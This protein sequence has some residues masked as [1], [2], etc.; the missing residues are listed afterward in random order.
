[1]K[2]VTMEVSGFKNY[3]ETHSFSF[4]LANQILGDRGKGKT[5][6]SEAI[7]WCLKGCD[8]QGNTRGIRKRLKNWAAKE[9][10]VVTEWDFQCNGNTVRHTFCRVSKG[11][12]TQLYLNGKET[13]QSEFDLL[14]GSTDSFLTIFSPG[15][16]G[17]LG[18]VKA[19]NVLLSW[20]PIQDHM[21]V[22]ESLTV[23]DQNQIQHFDMTDPLRCLQD[24]KIELEE[25]NGYLRD[26]E[27]RISSIRMGE[28]LNGSPE[29]MQKD[30]RKL[31]SLKQELED[32]LKTE[33][34]EVP[35]YLL[36]WETEL[37]AL[38]DHYRQLVN[39]WK[40]INNMPLPHVNNQK[41]GKHVRQAE[42]D[43]I[44][45]KCQS[46]L[47]QGFALK[48]QIQS[49][50]KHYEQDHVH[51]LMRKDNDVQQLRNNIHSLDAKQSVRLNNMK[52]AEGLTRMEKQIEDGVVERDKVLSEI[53]SVQNFMLKYAEMQIEMMNRNLSHTEIL[54]T[55]KR[56]AR[57]AITLQH[58]LLYDKKEYYSL[59][60]TE[61]I[62]CSFELSNLVCKIHGR[63]IPVFIDNGEWI[64][65]FMDSQTQCFV[66][67]LIPHA[68][69]SYEILVA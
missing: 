12:S 65:E 1:M 59:T 8:L 28:K 62:R 29:L 19:R 16:Y 42:L 63:S 53:Q 38:G 13:S 47:N 55:T 4:G 54:L 67:S 40:E 33:G 46:V 69:L 52:R 57:G 45:A 50:R 43:E 60:S 37:S 20:V 34:P 9:I 21:T 3:K 61:K 64:E 44:A 58:K 66:T 17:G 31:E 18:A 24:L 35:S 36:E 14:L 11:R 6:L 32:L 22:V 39:R 7:V 49:E 10:N 41:S 15:Y 25:W 51:F 30:E 27:I 68:A 23:S 48:E 2:L 56:D 26:M 5:A